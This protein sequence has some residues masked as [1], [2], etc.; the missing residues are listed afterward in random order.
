MSKLLRQEY[1]TY[2]VDS[3]RLK[4][5]YQDIMPDSFKFQDS[6]KIS[7]VLRDNLET[8]NKWLIENKLSLHMGKTEV[9]LFGSEGKLNKNIM[10]FLLRLVMVKPSGRINPLFI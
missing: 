10:I 4:N 8:C 6:E 1:M 9:I 7:N 2:D 3:V 5:L